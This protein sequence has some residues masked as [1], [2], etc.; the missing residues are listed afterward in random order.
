[1]ALAREHDLKTVAFPAIS[2]GV[3]GFPI[4]SAAKIAVAE[5]LNA[6]ESH[7]DAFEAIYLVSR[8]DEVDVALS[9]ALQGVR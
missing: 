2:C 8:E 1:M 5:I 9:E 7:P 6:L 3:Y 4:R